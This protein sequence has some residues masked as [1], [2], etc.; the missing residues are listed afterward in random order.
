MLVRTF[1]GHEMTTIV[2]QIKQDF[3]KQAVILGTEKTTL[4]ETN[5]TIYKVKAAIPETK[6]LIGAATSQQETTSPLTSGFTELLQRSEK[7]LHDLEGTISSKHSLQSIEHELAEIKAMLYRSSFLVDDEIFENTPDKIREIL[8]HLKLMALDQ[9]Y[10]EQIK[11]N[12]LEEFQKNPASDFRSLAVKWMLKRVKISPNISSDETPSVHV[13]I[14]S[15]GSGKTTS[16]AKTAALL[17][18]N[19]AKR[20]KIISLNNLNV[21][22]YEQLKI[23]AK[24]MDIPLL[25]ASTTEEFNEA[26]ERNNEKEITLVDT[27]GCSGKDIDYLQHLSTIIKSSSQLVRTHLVLPLTEK[28]MHLDQS[29]RT[30]STLGIHNLI[31]TKLDQTWTYGEIYNLASRWSIPLSFFSTGQEVPSDYERASR[32]RVVERIFRI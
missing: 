13:F 23:Y 15:P 16:L 19:E 29:I 14:G 22:S 27:S 3:G 25:S 5:K 18:A 30:F 9:S 12:L 1:E 21:G 2:K 26:L 10:M 24:V 6:Q 8:K 17:K 11:K 20:T 4:A 31:F 32:E 28:Q 7:I